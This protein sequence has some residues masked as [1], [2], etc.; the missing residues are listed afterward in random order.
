MV[1]LAKRLFQ[2][3]GLSEL[4]RTLWDDRI[5][6]AAAISRIRIKHSALKLNDL[7]PN[8]LRDEKVSSAAE[9]TP[10]SCWVNTK[11]VK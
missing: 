1:R 2:E 10:V 7:L 11:K 9:T 4:E 3:A 6:I 8:H 5:K